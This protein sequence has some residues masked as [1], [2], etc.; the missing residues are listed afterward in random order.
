MISINHDAK[1][2]A[3]RLVNLVLSCKIAESGNKPPQG[4]G[5]R[6]AKV[7]ARKILEEKEYPQE[8]KQLIFTYLGNN[9]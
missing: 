3:D 2:E 5:R 7:I 9:N 1:A 6:L 4:V 8:L